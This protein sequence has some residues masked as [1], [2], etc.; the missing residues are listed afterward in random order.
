MPCNRLIIEVQYQVPGSAYIMI[1]ATTTMLFFYSP[2]RVLLPG[3][4]PIVCASGV[5]CNAAPMNY[6]DLPFPLGV[7]CKVDGIELLDLKLA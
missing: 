4:N 2:A 7:L 1:A 5:R 3:L 6:I